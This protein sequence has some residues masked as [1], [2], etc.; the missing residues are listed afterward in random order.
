MPPVPVPV[1]VPV[2]IALLAV[3]TATAVAVAAGGC[4][5]ASSPAATSTSVAGAAVVVRVVDG[6]TIVVAPR[7]PPGEGPAHR[8]RHARD[9]EPD[10]AGAVLRQGGV[11]P[12]R[13]SCS[14]PGTAVRLERDAEERDA[15][16]RLLAYV[17]RLGD[18]LFVNL[19][20]ARGGYADAAYA[21]RPTWPTSPS[22]RPPST[23]PGATV[24]ACGASCGGPGRPAG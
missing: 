11:G 16:G 21:S 4:G 20:L 1:P 12:H 2:R 9:Q 24:P 22:S 6:D 15:Y 10:Q 8:H 17:Y 13:P 5:A 14:P 3:V 7:R 23:A 18:G 19:D